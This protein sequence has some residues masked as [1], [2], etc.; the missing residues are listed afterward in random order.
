MDCLYETRKIKGNF[1]SISDKKDLHNKIA[2]VTGSNK[3]IGLEIGKTLYSN[4]A[5][6]IFSNKQIN[7]LEITLNDLGYDSKRFS[8][9]KMDVSDK[10]EIINGVESIIQSFG[11]IDILINNAGIDF[12]S[13]FLDIND[14]LWERIFNVNFWGTVWLTQLVIPIMKTNGGGKIINISSQAGKFGEAF[15]S[16]YCAT[17]FAIIGLTQSLA[18]E[19]A[20]F[21]I[22]INAICPGPVETEMFSEAIGKFSEIYRIPIENFRK[23]FLD[24]IPGKQLLYPTQ[25]ASIVSFLASERSNGITGASIQITNGTTMW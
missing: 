1:M 9:I 24:N 10:N 25:I 8:I 11:R 3:G 22:S 17:K 19:F 15:N 20:Q 13:G 23:Q 6:V 4:G 12:I 2:L 7:N 18:K 14:E 5:Y 16:A 21:N